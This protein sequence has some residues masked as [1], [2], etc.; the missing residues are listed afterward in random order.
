MNKVVIVMT[1]FDRPY[2]LS[3]TLHS[4]VRTAYQHVEV[5]I[6][7]DSSNQP[8]DVGLSNIRMKVIR[9][10]HKRWTNP[11]PAYNVGIQEALDRG[12]DVVI[13][14]NAECYHVGDVVSAAAQVTDTNYISFPCFSI[15]EK[16]T[17]RTH[18][19]SALMMANDIGATADGQNA[20]Y[21]HAR[22]RPVAYDF[23]S[24]I[25]VKNIVE[26][27]GYDER[28]SAGWGYGDDYLLQRI[29]MMGLKVEIPNLPLVVHQWHYNYAG[30][31]NRKPLIERNRLL[32]LKLITEGQPKAKH[33]YTAD[34]I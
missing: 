6:V 25:T 5:V 27:N 8:P 1:Y 29:K 30:A 10:R 16:T 9:T 22:H 19:I 34:F 7:D 32:Y 2:Q 18:D 26:L 21:N 13:L 17:F 20:W 3:R 23:C 24:A 33:L 14:Q 31:A 28:F 12:A 11:E 4:I 15:N